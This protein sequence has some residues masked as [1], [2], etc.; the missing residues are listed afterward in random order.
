MVKYDGEM[1][2][3]KKY[4]IMTY[5]FTS[6]SICIDER[7]LK[8]KGNGLKIILIGIEKYITDSESLYDS[9]SFVSF[10]SISV[11]NLK[12]KCTD[13]ICYT[14]ATQTATCS[15]L[16]SVRKDYDFVNNP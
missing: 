2:I 11:S 16:M 15:L 9:C 14:S 3:W 6:K 5:N 7:N 13:V 10:E 8:V 4:K 12:E 1:Y